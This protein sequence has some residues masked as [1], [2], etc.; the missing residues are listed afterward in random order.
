MPVNVEGLILNFSA[1]SLNLFLYSRNYLFIENTTSQRI[2]TFHEEY[3]ELS[4]NV[5]TINMRAQLLTG[6]TLWV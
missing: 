2:L 4:N 3:R 5:I 6:I 1:D